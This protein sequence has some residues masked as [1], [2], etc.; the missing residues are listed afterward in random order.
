VRAQAC[1]KE[2]EK[3]LEEAPCYRK[4]SSYESS[5]VPSDSTAKRDEGKR[6][7]MSGRVCWS[8]L[9]RMVGLEVQVVST[10]S[11]FDEGHFEEALRLCLPNNRNRLPQGHNLF[12][13]TAF[14]IRKCLCPGTQKVNDRDLKKEL[15][16]GSEVRI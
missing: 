1:R 9:S 4:T 13:E 12:R 14:N 6:E 15:Q 3:E 7:K 8:T 5:S 11:H 10:A 16:I 2:A